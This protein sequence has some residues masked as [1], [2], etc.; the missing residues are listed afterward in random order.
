MKRICFALF[1]LFTVTAFAQQKPTDLDKSPLDYSYCPANYPI[2]KMNGKVKSEPVARIIYSRPQK[3]GREIFGGIVEYGEVWRLG[4]NEATEIEFFRNVKINGK[5]ISKGRYTMYAICTDTVWTIIFNS[6]K[7]VWGLYYNPNKDVYRTD[8]PLQHTAEPVEALTIYFDDMK[9][10]ALLNI[11][12]DTDKVS[13]P[14][15]F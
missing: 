4:A 9:G 12:W 14:I 2:L 13:L 3:L 7:D 5:T 15:N 6:E 1:S 8:V 11:M 10:G